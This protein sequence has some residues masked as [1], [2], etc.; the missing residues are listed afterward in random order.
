[1]IHEL[2]A[3]TNK[4]GTKYLYGIREDCTSIILCEGF[5]CQGCL[6]GLIREVEENKCQCYFRDRSFEPILERNL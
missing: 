5:S 4:N 1:M 6:Y 3:V 2:A